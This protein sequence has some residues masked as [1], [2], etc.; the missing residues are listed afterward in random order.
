MFL[1]FLINLKEFGKFKLRLFNKNIA[2]RVDVRSDLPNVYIMNGR[3]TLT[4]L[5]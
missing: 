1:Y 2:L 3:G 5:R 4:V